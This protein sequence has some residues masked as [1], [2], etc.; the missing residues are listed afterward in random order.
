MKNKYLLSA[1]LILL[2][3]S[4]SKGQDSTASNVK[5]SLYFE[6]NSV[7][8][9]RKD[10]LNTPYLTPS[11]GYFHKSGFYASADASFLMRT[12]ASRLDLT[13]ISAGYNHSFGNFTANLSGRK[14]F[15]NNSSTNVKAEVTNEI[16]LS[17][18]YEI[19]NFSIWLEP[20]VYP[21]K[22]TDY[23]FISGIGKDFLIGEH[24]DLF[25]NY[26][27][28]AQTRNFYS[29][30]YAKRRLRTKNGMIPVTVTAVVTGSD[31]MQVL[32][33]D[34]SFPLTYTK[35]NWSLSFTP[36]YSIASNPAVLDITF[37]PTIGPT[38]YKTIQEK[39][40][41][42]WWFSLEASFKL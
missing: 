1:I 42:T 6:N 25:A 2:F 40:S 33:S 14:Y 13:S 8:A 11:I 32:S 21:G 35:N 24:F 31:K 12:G 27:F 30:Y 37:K 16:D 19:K 36:T 3:V 34:F 10:S 18:T 20:G 23:Y 22:N 9:G 29:D 15:Y 41:N 26:S 38:I 17:L 4:V 5:F 28:N 39:I 7:Y